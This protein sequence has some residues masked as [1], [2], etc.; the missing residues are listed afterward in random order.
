[1]I[2]IPE[3]A[4]LSTKIYIFFLDSWQGILLVDVG[5][6]NVELIGVGTLSRMSKPMRLS[7]DHEI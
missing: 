7:K 3:L 2:L 5:M 1:M 6:V 4:L